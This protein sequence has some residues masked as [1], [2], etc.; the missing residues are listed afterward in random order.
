[1]KQQA[2]PLPGNPAAL[3]YMA[4]LINAFGHRQQYHY[5]IHKGQKPIKPVKTKHNYVELW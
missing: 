5:P 1:M 2:K 3:A 4:N